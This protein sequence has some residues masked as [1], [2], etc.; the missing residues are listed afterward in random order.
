MSVLRSLSQMVYCSSTRP[1][2]PCPHLYLSLAPGFRYERTD[3]YK[4]D[5]RSRSVEK[6]V[7]KS[8]S[9][10]LFLDPLVDKLDIPRRLQHRIYSNAGPTMVKIPRQIPS[11]AVSIFE[12]NHA[13]G[14]VLGR[15]HLVYRAG[16]FTS[17]RG[18][19]TV[20][21]LV[22]IPCRSRYTTWISEH[23]WMQLAFRDRPL[24]VEPNFTWTHSGFCIFAIICFDAWLYTGFS[25]CIAGPRTSAHTGR[26]P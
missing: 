26:Q 5:G 6:W 1:K 10:L 19:C 17:V 12:A 14:S 21:E 24:I 4:I 11:R 3:E 16:L 25:A 15:S 13:E 23:R 7:W 2:R 22:R 18:I 8:G 9:H 20:L